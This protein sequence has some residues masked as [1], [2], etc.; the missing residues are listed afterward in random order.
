MLWRMGR[1]AVKYSW[2]P[3]PAVLDLPGTVNPIVIGGEIRTAGDFQAPPLLMREAEIDAAATV[4]ARSL[5][6]L[7]GRFSAVPVTVVYIP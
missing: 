1:Y 7:R 4:Y 3:P 2:R 5:A 6:W